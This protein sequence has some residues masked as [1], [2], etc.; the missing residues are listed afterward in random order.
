MDA[1]LFSFTVTKL[2]TF[3]HAFQVLKSVMV[4]FTQLFFDS[5]KVG[6]SIA[7]LS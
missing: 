4:I 7:F 1:A 3:C 5:G 6:I 2:W